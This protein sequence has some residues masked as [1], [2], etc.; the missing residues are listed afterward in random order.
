MHINVDHDI[1][2]EHHC[3]HTHPHTHTSDTRNYWRIRFP[4]S[5]HYNLT[6]YLK[7]DY[8]IFL[9][10]VLY[11]ININ[12]IDFHLRMMERMLWLAMPVI[13]GGKNGILFHPV[14]NY[15][16]VFVMKLRAFHFFHNHNASLCFPF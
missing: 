2:L 12:K 7:H 8:T 15:S 4:Y 6:Q 1:Y 10:F 3:A 14:L 16:K 13:S 9:N 11:N 5:H